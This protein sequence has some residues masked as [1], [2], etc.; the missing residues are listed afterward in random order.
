LEIVVSNK[1]L[2][3]AEEAYKQQMQKTIESNFDL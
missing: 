3:K 1:L 2:E